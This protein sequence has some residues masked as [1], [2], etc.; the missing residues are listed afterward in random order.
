MDKKGTRF[1]KTLRD[2]SE[3]ALIGRRYL[4]ALCSNIVGLAAII[5]Y[6]TL[7]MICVLPNILVHFITKANENTIDSK[8]IASLSFSV[9]LVVSLIALLFHLPGTGDFDSEIIL[10]KDTYVSLQHGF[11]YCLYIKILK[12]IIGGKFLVI[13]AN[14]LIV[15]IV[16][17]SV[18]SYMCFWIYRRYLS[19]R[20]IVVLICFYSLL[21]LGILGN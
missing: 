6:V 10:N 14:S 9:V 8:Q 19:L 17:S 15:S 5:F 18:F 11:Y 2:Y 21:P 7:E 4:T 12:F 20:M 1:F 3:A 13:L 16:W